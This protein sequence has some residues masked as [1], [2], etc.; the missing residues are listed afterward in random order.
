MLMS[1][2]SKVWESTLGH[3]QHVLSAAVLRMTFILRLYH[4][5]N[6]RPRALYTRS[7]L[8]GNFHCVQKVKNVCIVIES[9]SY[10]TNMI[11]CAFAAQKIIINCHCVSHMDML[12]V[13]M[14]NPSI[15]V[16]IFSTHSNTGGTY[17][18]RFIAPL[19]DVNYL[20]ICLI[21]VINW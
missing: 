16:M 5:F 9:K 15:C 11:C 1:S 3:V 2:R 21:L 19:N 14:T 12:M 7:H 6:P 10:H 20:Q 13:L 4:P 8:G 17:K 18:Y